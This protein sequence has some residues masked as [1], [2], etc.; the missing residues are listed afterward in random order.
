MEKLG[1]MTGVEEHLHKKRALNAQKP[2]SLPSWSKRNCIQ[3]TIIFVQLSETRRKV[4][5]TILSF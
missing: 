5:G 2:T 3:D 4:K 1:V